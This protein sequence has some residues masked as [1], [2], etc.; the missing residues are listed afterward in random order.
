MA[1]LGLVSIVTGLGWA[2]LIGAGK[3]V[4]VCVRPC[5]RY[6]ENERVL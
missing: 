4:C 6:R 5:E 2:L 1:R 3:V